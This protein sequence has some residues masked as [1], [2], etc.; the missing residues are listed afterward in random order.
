MNLNMYQAAQSLKSRGWKFV[1]CDS[2]TA[3]T[4]WW[5]LPGA[6]GVREMRRGDPKPYLES[7]TETL[8]LYVDEEPAK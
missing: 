5:T 1:D 6:G 7:A 2:R 4:G 3:R 8:R